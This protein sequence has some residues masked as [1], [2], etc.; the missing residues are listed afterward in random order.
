MEPTEGTVDGNSPSSSDDDHE[1]EENSESD[2]FRQGE[3]N[4]LIRDLSLSKEKAELLAS[5]LKQKHLL[6]KGVKVS[7][8]R[9][10]NRDV[11]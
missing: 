8:Y 10:R 4:G 7:L 2:I 1:V 5:R 11:E 3:L 6:A 9:K